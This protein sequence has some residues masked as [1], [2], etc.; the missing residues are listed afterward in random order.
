MGVKK[1]S[2]FDHD[3]IEIHNLNRTIYRKEDIG[4]HKVFALKEI[5]ESLRDIEI[6]AFPSLCTPL[7][8]SCL[9]EKPEVIMDCSDRLD[10]Q[11]SIA[12][13]C[14]E[15]Q[16]R[17]IRAGATINHITVTSSVETW[18]ESKKEQC[19]VT[20]PSW[21]APV[22]L[23]AAYAVDKLAL[24]PDLEICMSLEKGK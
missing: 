12:N 19:G 14:T 17:Y 15:N 20:I 23:V 13:W 3:T 10:S 6:L 2:I 8:L 5:L 16:V 21:V 9:A 4:K 1:L 7:A 11:K 24:N 22:A 18:G